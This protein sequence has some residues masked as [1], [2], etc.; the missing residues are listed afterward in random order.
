MLTNAIPTVIKLANASHQNS[1]LVQG[2]LKTKRNDAVSIAALNN[3]AST[4]LTIQVTGLNVPQPK[5]GMIVIDA[6]NSHR[7]P[8]SGTPKSPTHNETAFITIVMNAAF[9]HLARVSHST[10]KNSII[11]PAP[12]THKE[13]NRIAKNSDGHTTSAKTDIGPSYLSRTAGRRLS[14]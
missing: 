14:C 9:A 7:M 11:N 5:S 8:D 1:L 12:M 6:I 2:I 4:Q 3:V 10:K 13:Y